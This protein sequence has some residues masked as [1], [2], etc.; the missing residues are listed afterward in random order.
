[1]RKRD[2]K[3][4]NPILPEFVHRDKLL[5]T[6]YKDLNYKHGGILLFDNL[7]NLV[8][9]H[10]NQRLL[11]PKNLELIKQI[12][13]KLV[14]MTVNLQVNSDSQYDRSKESV[15]RV[16]SASYVGGKINIKTSAHNIG[17]QAVGIIITAQKD[18]IMITAPN[19]EEIGSMLI[20]IITREEN[21]ST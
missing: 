2:V 14:G 16:M 10:L 8:K 9:D 18:H 1:M 21:L 20:I 4:E 3:A 12:M 6:D 7:Y 13:G 17:F 15:I 19:S 5:I 11:D